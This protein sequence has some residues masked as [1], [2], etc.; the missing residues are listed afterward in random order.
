MKWERF[1]GFL[2]VRQALLSKVG[3]IFLA[4][5]ERVFRLTSEAAS[6]APKNRTSSNQSDQGIDRIRSQN[7]TNSGPFVPRNC[8]MA[9]ALGRLAIHC[10]VVRGGGFGGLPPKKPLLFRIQEVGPS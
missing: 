1:M 5:W 7:G 10:W 2:D 9:G 3:A 8:W 6:R 4:R